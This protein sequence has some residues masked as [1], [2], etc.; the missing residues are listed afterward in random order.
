MLTFV[1]YQN[2]NDMKAKNVYWIIAGFLNLF[3]FF[4]HLIGG[5]IDI[6]NP[7]MESSMSLQ[8][9]S[10]MLAAWHLITVFLLMSS[11]YFIQIGFKNADQNPEQLVNFM[12]YCYFAFGL[13]FIVVSLVQ[14]VF[15][16]QWILLLPI[17]I[18]GLIGL[19]KEKNVK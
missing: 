12:S 15:T 9:M 18:L 7:M 17:G 6:V 2:E 8:P 10:E 16:P 5:Q 4:L 3:T 13:V 11:I 1:S 19:K 14:G